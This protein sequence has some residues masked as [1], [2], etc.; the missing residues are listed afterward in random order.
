MF[1]YLETDEAIDLIENVRE[2]GQLIWKDELLWF[3][4]P[5]NNGLHSWTIRV[6][7]SHLSK[8]CP[9]WSRG[10][11]RSGQGFPYLNSYGPYQSYIEDEVNANAF[12]QIKNGEYCWF[13][14]LPGYGPPRLIPIANYLDSTNP[15]PDWMAS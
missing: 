7:S 12:K 13:P 2:A 6:I 4:P 15:T 1:S 11:S 9:D 10:I 14:T 5:I 8:A 3:T